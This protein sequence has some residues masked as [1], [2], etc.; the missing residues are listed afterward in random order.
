MTSKPL[1]AMN[2]LPNK[3]NTNPA[4]RTWQK[5]PNKATNAT[6]SRAET[7]GVSV[8]TTATAKEVPRV[9]PMNNNPVKTAVSQPPANK[10]FDDSL[11]DLF[12]DNSLPDELLLALLDN[13]SD[14]EE[15]SQ[16]APATVPVMPCGTNKQ[17]SSQVKSGKGPPGR[18]NCYSNQ[19]TSSCSTAPSSNQSSNRKMQQ[20][21][22]SRRMTRSSASGY[23]NKSN[24]NWT[25]KQVP[26]HSATAT[27]SRMANASAQFTS[28]S[29]PPKMNGHAAD[30]ED[31][32]RDE[33]K[34]GRR[35]LSQPVTP[36]SKKGT[37][38]IRILSVE[39]QKGAIAIDIDS[40]SALLALNQISLNIDSTLLALNIYLFSCI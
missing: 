30:R 39:S 29:Y 16:K 18:P 24:S 4:H 33:E 5:P 34:T 37:F 31:Y 35:S 40:D 26:G 13:D 38:S 17:S 20:Q 1:I 19:T 8:R 25:S 6:N 23:V 32:H 22:S 7:R 3:V 21:S 10:A 15:Y 12:G 28:S 2:K 36:T 27:H 11:D 14:F 9:P